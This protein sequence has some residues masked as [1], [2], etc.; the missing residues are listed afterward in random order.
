MSLEKLFEHDP[1]CWFGKTIRTRLHLTALILERAMAH[2]VNLK[3]GLMDT[4]S[5]VNPKTTEV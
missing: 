4:G 1:F 3:Y 5:E 2:Y